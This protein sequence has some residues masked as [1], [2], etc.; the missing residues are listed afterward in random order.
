MRNCEL[1]YRPFHGCAF[2]HPTKAKKP[3]SFWTDRTTF[4]PTGTTGDG[5]CSQKCG[6]GFRN[7]AG[8][9]EHIGK[10]GRLPKDGPQ[11]PG[12][13]KLKNA[14]PPMFLCEFAQECIRTRHHPRQRVVIDLCAGWQSWRPVCEELGLYYVAVDIRGDRN[15]RLQTVSG[16]AARGPGGC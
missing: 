3:Y 10:L 16:S 14:V 12:A 13:S 2:N 6:S 9:W 8:N 7:E 15:R 1:H 5:Q 11:G 4:W